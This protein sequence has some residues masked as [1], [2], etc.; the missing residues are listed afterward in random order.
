MRKIAE[1]IIATAVMI[2][3]IALISA[4]MQALNLWLIK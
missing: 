1:A 2:G 3:L 4:A